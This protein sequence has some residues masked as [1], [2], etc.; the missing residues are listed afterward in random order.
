[1]T[2][3]KDRFILAGYRWNS[4]DMVSPFADFRDAVA[5]DRGEEVCE[6]PAPKLTA[7]SLAFVTRKSG[8]RVGVM[9]EEAGSAGVFSTGL[10]LCN[11]RLRYQDQ[12]SK[13]ICDSESLA[14]RIKLF[15]GKEIVAYRHTERSDAVIGAVRYQKTF[16]GMD[17]TV[18]RK[19]GTRHVT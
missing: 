12:C 8:V 6:T 18:D 7:C 9:G 17:G 2:C 13:I 16:A 15:T 11:R 3:R 10:R 4:R 5:L 1:M 14:A 19:P